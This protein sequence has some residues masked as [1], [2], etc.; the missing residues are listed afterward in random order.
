MTHIRL[1]DPVTVGQIAAGEVIERPQSV[2]KELVENAV[3][4]GAQRITVAIAGGGADTIEVIDD[5]HGI[6]PEDLA[7]AVRRHATSKLVEADDLESIATK[8][9]ALQ[10][11]SAAASENAQAMEQNLTRGISSQ[12]EYR[13]AQNDLLGVQTALLTLARPDVLADQPSAGLLFPVATWVSYKAWRAMN[14]SGRLAV[15]AVAD[16]SYGSSTRSM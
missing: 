16:A 6:D 4:A 10:S 5:G 14:D 11:A 15:R 1:L 3:D 12:Y 8:Q 9:K 13:L 7:L 2:V